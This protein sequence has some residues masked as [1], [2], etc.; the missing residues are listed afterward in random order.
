MCTSSKQ[1]AADMYRGCIMTGGATIVTQICETHK[2]TT[3]VVLSGSDSRGGYIVAA[4]PAT[5]NLNSV[6]VAR[7]GITL[8]NINALVQLMLTTKPV[9]DWLTDS[10]FAGLGMWSDPRT[11]TFLLEPCEWYEDKAVA[12]TLASNRGQYA[13]YDLGAGTEVTL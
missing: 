8:P 5:A 10:P 12:L 4:D 1:L 6:S 3:L 13:I 2:C 11:S 7:E 9:L